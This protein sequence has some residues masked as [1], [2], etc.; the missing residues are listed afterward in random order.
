MVT[1]NDPARAEKLRILRAHGSKPKYYH[2]LVGGNFRLDTLQ[3]AIVLVKLR[4]LDAWTAARQANAAR[5]DR[6][7]RD[8]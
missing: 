4:H 5:Y 6:L 1:T 7:F 2:K 8:S 3:A